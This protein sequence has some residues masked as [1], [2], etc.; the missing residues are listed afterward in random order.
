MSLKLDEVQLEERL[1]LALHG[2]CGGLRVRGLPQYRRARAA[3]L[4]EYVEEHPLEI[5]QVIMGGSKRHEAR[6]AYTWFR[7]F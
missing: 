1:E 3:P 5:A 4:P 2:T 6:A 7:C